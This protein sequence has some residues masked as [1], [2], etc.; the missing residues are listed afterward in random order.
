VVVTVL[1][2]FTKS[3]NPMIT[4][5]IPGRDQSRLIHIVLDYNGTVAEDGIIFEIVKHKLILLQK[6]LKIHVITADTFGTVKDEMADLSVEVITI[7]KYNQDRAK[8]KFVEELGPE[9]VV[10]IGNGRNDG[11]M[12]QTSALGILVVNSEGASVQSLLKADV[13]CLSISDALDLLL[14]PKRLIATL[15]N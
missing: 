11:L 7:P 3:K 1:F 5:D 8:K 12:L 14:K 2:I 15:R 13:M 6:S 10:S 9:N 4:F